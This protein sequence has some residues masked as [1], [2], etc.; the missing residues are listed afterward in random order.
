[1]KRLSVPVSHATVVA[2]VSA[3]TLFACSTS[4][5]AQ[6]IPAPVLPLPLDQARLDG[7]SAALAYPNSSQRF[8]EAGNEQLEQEIQRLSEVDDNNVKSLL[9]VHPEVIEQFED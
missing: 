6:T 3:T 5:I 4:A 1:M 8:F 7:L 9:T 2:L